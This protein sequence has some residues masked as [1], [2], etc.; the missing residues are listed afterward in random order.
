MIL[1]EEKFR[2]YLKKRKV[3][4]SLIEKYIESVKGFDA[5]LKNK[6][7]VSK[8][9][10]SLLYQ[11]RHYVQS[12]KM[13]EEEKISFLNVLKSY[14]VAANAERIVGNT[15]RLLGQGGW[16]SRLSETLD[17]HVGEETR[18]KIMEAGGQIKHSSTANKKIKWIKCM[19]DCLEANVDEE[20]CKNILQNNLHYKNPKTP[21]YM[22]L[23]KMYEKSGIDTVLEFLHNKW[24]TRVGDRYGND[25]PE[26]EF[27]ANDPTIEAGK[28]EGNIIYV[29]KIPFKL[30][31]YL[32]A[33]NDKDK[34]YH[35]CHCG[36]IKASIPKS[37]EE[38]ISSTFCN[39]SGG[40]HKIPFE[41]IFGRT[42][43]VEVVKSVLKGDDIC[44]FAIHIPEEIEL[45]K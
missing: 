25:S 2:E 40:W 20:T 1:Q 45:D 43:R 26:Y 13:N 29:S 5:F 30:R 35:Y 12:L 37:D 34:R 16:L 36:W 38:Q 11:T 17:E 19:M 22:K 24:K 21:A 3:D 8:I 15:N 9:D 7:N 39:C 31:E 42:L 44:T 32:N 27:V 28:R 14:G 4:Q 41:T 33:K 18:T 23:K 6:F 10:K